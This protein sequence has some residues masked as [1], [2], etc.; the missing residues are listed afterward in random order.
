[1]IIL[2]STQHGFGRDR[3]ISSGLSPADID[4]ALGIG[5]TT[6]CDGG[7]TEWEWAFTADGYLCGIWDYNG[8]RWS[9]YGPRWVFV[10]LFGEANVDKDTLGVTRQYAP[11]TSAP[12]IPAAQTPT[13]GV[14]GMEQEAKA[15][16]AAGTAL[17]MALAGT[18]LAALGG[19]PHG[20]TLVEDGSDGTVYFVH[21]GVRYYA[22]VQVADD[23]QDLM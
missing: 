13:A 11:V 21:E 22:V 18:G 10:E 20:V 3:R 6:P 12:A 5:T 2:P 4:A 16:A 17:S 19:A 1:M 14:T 9:A 8:T 7:K 15:L 23:Q